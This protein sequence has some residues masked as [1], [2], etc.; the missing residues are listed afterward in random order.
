MRLSNGYQSDSDTYGSIF[1]KSGLKGFLSYVFDSRDLFMKI[2]AWVTRL[3]RHRFA[4]RP[5]GEIFMLNELKVIKK[6]WALIFTPVAF[7]ISVFWS[8]GSRPMFR[9]I[10]SQSWRNNGGPGADPFVWCRRD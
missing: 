5:S 6:Y 7:V 4:N 8:Q 9:R 3:M 2:R 10:V 1:L